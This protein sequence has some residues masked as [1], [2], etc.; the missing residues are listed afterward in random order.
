MTMSHIFICHFPLPRRV[1]VRSLV[2]LHFLRSTLTRA[3]RP[4]E[5]PTIHWVGELL[6]LFPKQSLNQRNTF[7]SFHCISLHFVII[8]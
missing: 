5:R 3:T 4:D 2:R 6:L 7:S 1:S 8:S